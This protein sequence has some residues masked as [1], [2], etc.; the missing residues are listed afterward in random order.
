MAQTGP[1]PASRHIRSHHTFCFG[2]AQKALLSE[3]L[4]EPLPC[5]NHTSRPLP[6][7]EGL[8]GCSV[9][10]DVI[11]YAIYRAMII[12]TLISSCKNAGA[13]VAGRPAVTLIT[14]PR[15]WVKTPTAKEPLLRT[16]CF[17]MLSKSSEVLVLFF[18]K[19]W[20]GQE[21]IITKSMWS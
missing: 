7:P 2:I 17:N 13:G 21:H 20:Y 11:P 12:L 18:T 8:H 19:F 10:G 1:A 5:T 4:S 6:E 14:R 3:I 16:A 9:L 15:T